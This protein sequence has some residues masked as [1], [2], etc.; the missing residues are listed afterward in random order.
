LAVARPS[1]VIEKMAKKIA[2]EVDS[3]SAPNTSVE[4][5]SSPAMVNQR[6]VFTALAPRR[7]IQSAAAP[8]RI[9]TVPVPAKLNIVYTLIELK[10][11]L[12]RSTR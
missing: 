12:R 6:R 11:R 8:A 3:D 2:T 5:A 4:A 1:P 10:L 7:M 9:A